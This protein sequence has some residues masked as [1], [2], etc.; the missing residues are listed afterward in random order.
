[1]MFSCDSA[2]IGASAAIVQPQSDELPAPFGGLVVDEMGTRM[3]GC[4]VID[5]LDLT[6][7][8]IELDAQLRAVEDDAQSGEC[9]HRLVIHRLAA[10]GIVGADLQQGEPRLQR[11]VI[12]EDR[13]REG[14]G[15][16][17][18]VLA[19]AIVPEGT[20]EPLEQRRLGEQLDRGGLQRVSDLTPRA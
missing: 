11:P 15:L 4:P 17:G 2:A 10:Q 8:E 16:V 7:L 13:G 19:M 14:R 1:M 12:F 20:V 18:R 3:A 6:G 9:R 5:E